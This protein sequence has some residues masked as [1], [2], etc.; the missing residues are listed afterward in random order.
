[1][2]SSSPF[3]GQTDNI[4]R[5]KFCKWPKLMRYLVFISLLPPAFLVAIVHADT[6]S[7]N[8]VLIPSIAASAL[9]ILLFFWGIVLKVKARKYWYRNY[10]IGKTMLVALLPVIASSYML[11]E[12]H[13][14][15]TA[16]NHLAPRSVQLSVN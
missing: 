12:Q 4:F 10:H 6:V 7:F 13:E 8:E 14:P 11:L 1:M 9:N 15:K 2:R 3:P 5:D 16:A